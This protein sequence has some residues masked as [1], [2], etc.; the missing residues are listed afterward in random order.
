MKD[1]THKEFEDAPTKV[2]YIYMCA[3][4]KQP[5]GSS[6]YEDAIK[7]HPEYFLDEIEHRKKWEAIPKEVHDA[8]WKEHCKIKEEVYKDV[9]HRG[10]GMLFYVQNPKERDEYNSAQEAA[11]KKALPLFETLHRKFY[12][13]YGIEWNGM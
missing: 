12:S 5:I 6:T 1:L 3:V 8:Y 9:P 13:K 7:E 2:Q 11:N 4:M 10:K